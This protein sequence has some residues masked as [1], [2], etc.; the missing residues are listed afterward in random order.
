MELLWIIGKRLHPQHDLVPGMGLITARRMWNGTFTIWHNAKLAIAIAV[1]NE[2]FAT[3]M[4]GDAEVT[5]ANPVRCIVELAPGNVTARA[6]QLTRRHTCIHRLVLA[7][8][9]FRFLAYLL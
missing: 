9:V 1:R 6:H 8:E 3:E 2:G 5:N 4:R 7:L